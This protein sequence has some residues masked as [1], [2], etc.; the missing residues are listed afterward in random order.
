M[1]KTTARLQ[2]SSALRWASLGRQHALMKKTKV[3]HWAL[4]SSLLIHGRQEL[5]WATIGTKLGLRPPEQ[6]GSILS[7][8]LRHLLS[9]SSSIRPSDADACIE[10]AAAPMGEH[11]AWRAQCG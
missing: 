5:L 7:Q 8:T 2:T 11:S 6:A 4:T 10:L 1:M 9:L 3:S